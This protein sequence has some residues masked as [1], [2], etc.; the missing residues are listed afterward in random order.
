[1]EDWRPADTSPEAMKVWVEALRRLPP[2]RKTALV[3]EMV[4]FMTALALGDIRRSQPGISEYDALRELAA[5]RYGRELAEKA[6]PKR[7]REESDDRA[8]GRLRKTA[9]SF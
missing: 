7:E 5:R 2:G 8:S 4:D 1:M 3:F 9:G 6:Y